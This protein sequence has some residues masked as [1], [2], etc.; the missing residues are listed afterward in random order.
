MLSSHRKLCWKLPT[1][2][3]ITCQCTGGEIINKGLIS[4]V[5]PQSQMYPIALILRY[6]SVQS[7]STYSSPK[8]Q[9][10]NADSLWGE[11]G[12][13]GK[14]QVAQEGL[15]KLEA[16]SFCGKRQETKASPR[17][18]HQETAMAS[19]HPSKSPERGTCWTSHDSRRLSGRKL[20]LGFFFSLSY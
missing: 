17:R 8:G 19:L 9:R 5:L 3:K 20:F 18:N 1:S 15:S 2:P 7:V 13:E 14:G 16:R 6:C 10:M 4:A 12:V 11:F